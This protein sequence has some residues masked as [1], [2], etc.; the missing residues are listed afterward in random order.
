MKRHPDKYRTFVR[1]GKF[2]AVKQEG[3]GADN[4]HAPPAKQG[5]YA[6]P[7]VFQEF[8]LIGSLD[9]TQ[10]KHT[11]MP[12]EPSGEASSEEWDE[13]HKKRR[14]RLTEIRHEFSVDTKA[15]FWHHLNVPNKDVLQRHGTWVKTDYN[16]WKKA[17]IKE[18]TKLRFKSLKYVDTNNVNEVPKQA[19]FFSF[20]HM[21]EV[22][23]DY[24]IGT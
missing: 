16:T 6:M 23:F 13:Y 19:G 12:K 14:A 2:G 9:S 18:N 1:F 8:F 22:F 17:L 24:K 10:P 4:Y 11:G 21:A 5:F 20:D 7:L 15:E 3:F